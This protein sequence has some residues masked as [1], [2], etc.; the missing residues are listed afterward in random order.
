MAPS[1]R[2][3]ERLSRLEE[4]MDNAQEQRTEML[5]LIQ[6][7]DDRVRKLERFIWIA[8]GALAVLQFVSPIVLEKLNGP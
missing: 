5:E 6:K 3:G 1:E 7:L 2:P 8:F 4:R